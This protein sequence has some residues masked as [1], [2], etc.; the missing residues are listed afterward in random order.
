MNILRKNG[1]PRYQRDGIASWLLVAES[2]AGARHLT[3][4]L[5]EMSP[6]G[7]QHLHCHATEQSYFIIS[8]N[9]LMQVG[10]QT[11]R[12]QPGDTVFISGDTVHGLVNDSTVE[13][14][15]LG[16]GSPPFGRESEPGLRPLAPVCAKCEKE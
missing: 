4:T 7:R 13:L 2:T 10:E 15:Y 11:E 16:A 1:A 6:G 9:G 5:V 14:M 8:G 3:T 12:V